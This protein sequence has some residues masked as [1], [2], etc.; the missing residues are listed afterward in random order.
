MSLI[1]SIA[2]RLGAS[3][4]WTTFYY[5]L[6]LSLWAILVVATTTGSNEGEEMGRIVAVA[7]IVV[8]VISWPLIAFR[9]PR[10]VFVVLTAAAFAALV[11]YGVVAVRMASTR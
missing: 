1:Y 5:G 11:M 4:W 10:S 6:V 8:G 7:S 2:E 3:R 9:V